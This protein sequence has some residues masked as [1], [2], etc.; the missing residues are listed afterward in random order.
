MFS[1][2]NRP[3]D[4]RAFRREIVRAMKKG[5]HPEYQETQVHCA[6]GNEFATRSTLPSIQVEICSACHPFF[7]GT[8]KIMD[9]EG[10]VE[11]FRK[12]Y[13]TKT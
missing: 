1:L 13:A 5:I 3:A 4:G 11:R 2:F 8:Q 10:R 7:T 12:R 6:C 9:T